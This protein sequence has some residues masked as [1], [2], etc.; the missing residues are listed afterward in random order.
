MGGRCPAHDQVARA[1]LHAAQRFERSLTADA[2][3]ND[4]DAA[5]RLHLIAKRSFYDVI[6]ADGAQHVQF[7]GAVHRRDLRSHEF[8]ELYCVGTDTSA[9]AVDQ[10]AFPGANL[11]RAPRGVI[12]RSYKGD[13]A[14]S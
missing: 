11:C 1:E 5:E 12:A 8:G 6:G 4:V 3:V 2:V 14:R 13:L 9:F 7:F 10:D